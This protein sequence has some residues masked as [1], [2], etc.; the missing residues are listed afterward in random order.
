MTI[1]D[2]SID[3]SLLSESNIYIPVSTDKAKLEWDGNDATILGLLFETGRYYRRKGLFQPLLRDRSVA[4]SNGRLAVEH[5]SAVHF[6]TGAI[7]ENRGFYDPCPPTVDRLQEHNDEV[8]FG[9][10]AGTAREG[11]YYYMYLRAVED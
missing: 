10:H 4:L 6:L 3:R 5:P 9:T 1:S 8:G 11:N 2:D 7:T